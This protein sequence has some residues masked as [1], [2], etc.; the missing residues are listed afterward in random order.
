MITTNKNKQKKGKI[1]DV[2]LSNLTDFLAPGW[3]K[4]KIKNR[5]LDYI[6][7]IEGT[8]LSWI[9]KRLL[10]L[11]TIPPQ[12]QTKQLIKQLRE[13]KE[14][15][16]NPK[17]EKKCR[18]LKKLYYLNENIKIFLAQNKKEIKKNITKPKIIFLT[19]L[20]HIN[21]KSGEVF[22]LNNL[23]NIIQKE[24]DFCPLKIV[25]TPPSKRCYNSLL[26]QITSEN[27]FYTFIRKENKQR[28]KN[29]AQKLSKQWDLITEEEKIKI[30]KNKSYWNCLRYPLDF[31]FSKEFIYFVALYYFTYQEILMKNNAQAVIITSQH[32]IHERCLSAV[33]SKQNIPVVLI[34]HGA[35]FGAIN[36]ALLPPF[37]IA[38]FSKYY[39]QMLIKQKVPPDRII[40]T[41]PLI[42]DDIYPFLK[43]NQQQKA[44]N[45]T[46]ILILTV[47]FVEQSYFSKE[48]HANYIKMIIQEIQNIPNAKIMIK[49][50]PLE[51]NLK[52]YQKIIRLSKNVQVLQKTGAS[53]LY[54]LISESDIIINFS[55]TVAL[56]S[57]ILNKPVITILSKEFTNPFN[58]LISESKATIELKKLEELTPA[59]KKLIFDKK[60]QQ[61]L[62]KK[63]LI[64]TQKL[65]G[66]LDGKAAERVAE[67]VR[68]KIT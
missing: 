54:Q 15:L 22:R 5:E 4:Q 45:Q 23:L 34:Q 17:L 66:L 39:K 27:T 52:D 7:Q 51:K 42:F 29:I 8:P 9:Y 31:Y 68:K 3:H 60:L 1:T 55:S 58:T 67:F 63:R 38:T 36:P 24:R 11:H 30:F 49:L 64:F 12:F 18:H 16:F 40:V 41:G 21:P 20:D 33:A 53:F 19:Y 10:S 28:A 47:P 26:Q 57:I 35:G 25:V 14:L 44:N 50:H 46:K 2:G 37:F 6:F 56:E 43:Y 62:Y 61:E 32:S 59:I 48:K 13:G 65:C